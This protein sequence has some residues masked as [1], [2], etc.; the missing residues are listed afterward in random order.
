MSLTAV[1][2]SRRAVGLLEKAVLGFIAGAAGAIGI[3]SL[4]F[5]VLRIVELATG[6]ET[7]LVGAFLNQP[8]TTAFDSPSVVSASTNTMDVTLRDAPDSVRAW[9]I[10]AD[11]ARSLSSIGICAVVAWLC[12]RLFVGKPFVRTVTWGIGIVAILVLLSG[13]AAP[14]FD[15]IAKAQA[16]IALDLDELAPFLVAIDPA[17]IGWAFA[18]IVVAG[19]FEIG[20][21]LQHDS[22]GLV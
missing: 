8:V 18:L 17:P 3:V 16:A 15:G 11:M 6:A 4:V 5:L 19:A 2:P 9:L 22:E 10:G 1:S 21:R 13:M 7:T 14:L 12:L 20:G